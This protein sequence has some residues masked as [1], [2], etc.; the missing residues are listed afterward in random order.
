[1]I[2]TF[3]EA[4]VSDAPSVLAMSKAL[5]AWDPLLSLRVLRGGALYDG[6]LT[7]YATATAHTTLAFRDHR[8]EVAPGDAIVFPPSV[9][10]AMVPPGEFV[11]LRHEGLA[12]EQMRGTYPS[13]YGFSHHGLQSADSSE[14][15][16]GRRRTVI[17]D[18]DLR[19]RMQYH[20]VETRSA[21]VHS[22]EEMTEFYLV[23]SGTGDIRVGR[24]ASELMPV[25]V[26]PGSLLL[27]GPGMSHVPTD[28]LGL[29]IWFLYREMV[30]KCRIRDSVAS[31]P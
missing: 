10:I 20:F 14:S 26:R 13:Q 8:V 2:G 9:R 11:A 27:V 21:E 28:G 4:H 1:M 25:A 18:T 5:T 19:F 30:H 29:A 15:I 16:C 6:C 17:P 7:S 31:T 22:H 12:P 23:L 3:V 24:S